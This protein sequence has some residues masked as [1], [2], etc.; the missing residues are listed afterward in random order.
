MSAPASPGPAE[1]GPAWVVREAEAGATATGVP[2]TRSLSSPC[3]AHPSGAVAVAHG[4]V[5]DADVVGVGGYVPV[6][7]GSP[8]STS[9][10]AARFA[11]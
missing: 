5:S 6:P 1:L 4:G 3:I 9:T 7:R 11:S 10:P 8:S 2:W